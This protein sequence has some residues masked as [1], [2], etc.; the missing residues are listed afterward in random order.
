[1]VLNRLP[2]TVT[3]KLDR[4]ALPRPQRIRIEEASFVPPRPGAE[5]TLANIW[6]EALQIDRVGAADNFFLLGGHSLLAVQVQSRIQKA[7]G[8][9]LPLAAIFDEQTLSALALRLESNGNAPWQREIP[10]L[11]P[12]VRTEKMPASYA[13][14]TIWRAEQAE[15]CLFAHWIDVALRI[16]G[17]IDLPC[18]EQSVHEAVQRH[19]ILRTVFLSSGDSLWQVVL[20]SNVADVRVIETADSASGCPETDLAARPPFRAE[21]R[22]IAKDVHTLR[23]LIHRILCDG[24]STRLLLSEIAAIY[25][26]SRGASYLPLLDSNV[27]YT[28][29]A[30][31]ERSWLTGTALS[32]QVEFFRQGFGQA[33]GGAG[34]M[35]ALPPDTPRPLR[36]LRRGDVVRFEL[37]SEVGSA[38]ETLAVREQ[39]SLPIVLLAAFA[40]SLLKPNGGHSIAIASAVSRR[41]QPGTENILGP[42][43]NS[44]PLRIDLSGGPSQTLPELT[45]QVKHS[46]IAALAHA[47]AP[48]HLVKEQLAAEYGPAASDVGEIAFVM[49]DPAPAEFQLGDIFL[50][51]LELAEITARREIT[52]SVTAADG[53]VSGA[54]VYDRDL[55]N[56]QTMEEIVKR[57]EAVLA[58]PVLARN[59]TN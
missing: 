57:F 17:P 4:A 10:P 47:D 51:R 37:P 6:R 13:Q 26:S 23:L 44:L 59:A 42:F 22:R 2:V 34:A 38:A 5:E 24:L 39:A 31:W 45:R 12:V 52:L 48:F 27:D 55:F 18:L 11:V 49:A 58:Q 30:V 8:V 40:G 20:G 35:Y 3:G 53:D 21:I 54:I 19:E 25:A 9:E 36:R 56:R 16:R 28:D 46:M 7:F 1:M 33:S 29:Y 41:S 32:R 43:M 50:K 14:E 15:P